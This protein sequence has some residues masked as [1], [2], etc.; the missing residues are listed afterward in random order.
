VAHL[1]KYDQKT[2]RKQYHKT[3]HYDNFFGESEKRSLLDSANTSF[4]LSC[5]HWCLQLL[6]FLET[7]V[8]KTMQDSMLYIYFTAHINTVTFLRQYMGRVY[9]HIVL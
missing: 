5:N 1:E 6:L 3:L 9:S 4:E 2:Q 8:T 7:V